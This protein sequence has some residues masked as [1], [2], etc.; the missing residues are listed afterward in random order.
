MKIALKPLLRYASLAAIA[1]AGTLAHATEGCVSIEVQN[2]RQ[3]QGQLML[4]A[5]ADAESFNQKALA[6]LKA[7]AGDATTRLEMC[8]IGGDTLAIT[9]FQ[10]LDSDGKLGR[11]LMGI[12]LEPWGSSGTP[13][14][15][16]PTWDTGKVNLD[17]SVIVI[18]LS[19]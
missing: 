17:G 11:N 15:F 2:V 13:G 5:Y 4:A 3:H 10:D 16:G 14:S 7:P 18:K 9:M 12:P 6:T 1:L 8:G 19:S